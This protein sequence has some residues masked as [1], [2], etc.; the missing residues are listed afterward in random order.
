[1]N[2][3]RWLCCVL[4]AVL[5]GCATPGLYETVNPT[6]FAKIKRV[7]VLSAVGDKVTYHRQGFLSNEKYS[8]DISSWAI[9]ETV[10]KNLATVLADLYGMEAVPRTP[11]KPDSLFS[12]YTGVITYGGGGNVD[13]AR[14]SQMVGSLMV[15]ERAD[16]AIMVFHGGRGL[17]GA[18]RY[19]VSE[20][21]VSGP[22]GH[23]WVAPSPM[24]ALI[25][26]ESLRPIA[27]QFVSREFLGTARSRRG[28]PPETPLPLS[29]CERKL[30]NLRQEELDELRR[31]LMQYFDMPSLAGGAR[32]LVQRDVPTQW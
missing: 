30:Q 8:L 1:M 17:A 13:F 14:V 23:C 25:D 9:D 3:L 22:Q 20:P 16:A 7:V 5:S 6:E 15:Q 19:W 11:R 4:L 2:N 12:L 24:I 18:H 29:L 26:K 21:A 28:L 32:S 10:A 27:T 31:V